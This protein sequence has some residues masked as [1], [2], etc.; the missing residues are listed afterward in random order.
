MRRRISEA[1]TYSKTC[2]SRTALPSSL[3]SSPMDRLALG[4][5]VCATET[6]M[7]CTVWR[8]VAILKPQRM[9]LDFVSSV[10]MDDSND[11]SG[12][13]GGS[14]RS[15]VSMPGWGLAVMLIVRACLTGQVA[16]PSL[17]A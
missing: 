7:D 13:M 2:S 16:D 8:G 5:G 11:V 1:D 12:R 15:I 10:L 6:V 9:G 17:S 14:V 3:N 4:A